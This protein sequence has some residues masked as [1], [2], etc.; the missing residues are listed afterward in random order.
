MH[1]LPPQ[2]VCCAVA[3]I[4]LAAHQHYAQIITPEHV[5]P[6]GQLMKFTGLPLPVVEGLLAA[7]VLHGLLGVLWPGSPTYDP[8]NQEVRLIFHSV[9]AV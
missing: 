3:Y 2:S 7:F 6:I 4:L 5:G 8:R 9:Q 1:V